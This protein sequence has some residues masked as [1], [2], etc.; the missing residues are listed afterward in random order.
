MRATGLGHCHL[1]LDDVDHQLILARRRPSIDAFFHCVAHRLFLH[2]DFSR[3][4]LGQ[5]KAAFEGEIVARGD[6]AAAETPEAM[7]AVLVGMK[8]KS[9]P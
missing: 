7:E 6:V 4:S 2:Y 5:Y 1:D 3:F 8:K 9:V